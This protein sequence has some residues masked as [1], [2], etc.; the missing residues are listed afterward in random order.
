MENDMI[1]NPEKFKAIV[2]TKH[3]YQTA[4]SKFNFSGRTIHS[5]AEVDLL[6][7]K[8]DTKLSFK[9]YISKICKKAAGKLNVLKCLQGSQTS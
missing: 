4:G 3:D 6:G 2:L 9:S 5:S 7:I 8:L 1:A